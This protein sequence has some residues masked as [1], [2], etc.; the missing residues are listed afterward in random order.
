[1]WVVTIFECIGININ[2]SYWD[3]HASQMCA[4]RKGQFSNV[5][6]ITTKRN[7][8]KST[9]AA[10]CRRSDARN[11]VGYRYTRQPAATFK[12]KRPDA[13]H[14]VGDNQILNLPA[15]EIEIVSIVKW[16]GIIV[17]K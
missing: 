7:I 17:P 9:T 15:V 16:I 11:A 12:R 3:H 14:A 1:M 6:H 2:H 4:T 13:R 10:K 8:G 5:R